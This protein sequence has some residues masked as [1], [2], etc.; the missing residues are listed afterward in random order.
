MLKMT[1]IKK[2]DAAAIN[3]KLAEVRRELFDTK[4]KKYTTG[5]EKTHLIPVMRR[6][7]ARLL[8]VLNSKESK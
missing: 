2:L 1:D 6:N 4:F 5:V 8:T 7:I 3:A